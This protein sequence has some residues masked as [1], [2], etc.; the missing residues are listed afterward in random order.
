MNERDFF[1]LITEKDNSTRL[2]FYSEDVRDEAII[3]LKTISGK[4]AAD[5]GAGTGFIS[6]GLLDAELNVIAADT[7][8]AMA[9]FMKE[10]FADIKEFSVI[11]NDGDIIKLQDN[12]VDYAFAN[13]H[14]HHTENPGQALKEIQR[15][16]KPGGKA[17][18]TDFISHPYQDKFEN[19]QN[20]WPGFSFPDLYEW[21]I[22]AG[23]RNISIENLNHSCIIKDEKGEEF[24]IDIFIAA[25]EK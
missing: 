2:E 12:S 4:T 17:A 20:R 24:P 13:M 10:K 25:G 23:F 1:E 14:L 18:V 6:E 22:S 8:P 11:L 21:F 9:A 5:I 3:Q 19:H 16:L 7:S 15:I